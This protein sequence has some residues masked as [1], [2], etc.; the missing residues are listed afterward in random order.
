M[1]ITGTPAGGLDAAGPG[2]V[3]RQRNLMDQ[4]ALVQQAVPRLAPGSSSTC[5]PASCPSTG[6]LEPAGTTTPAG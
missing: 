6:A 3:A 2:A 5:W 1:V 4:T